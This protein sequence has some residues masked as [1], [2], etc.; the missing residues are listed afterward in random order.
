[1]AGTRDSY[2]LEKRFIR[3][4]GEVVHV[5][6]SVVPV[7]HET[8]AVDY[9]LILAQDITKRKRAEEQ[10]QL[11]KF[12]VDRSSQPIYWIRTDGRI[13]YANQAACAALG[14]SFEELVSMSVPQIDPDF[15][16]AAWPK[17]WEEMKQSGSMTFEARHKRKD[18]HMFPVELTTHY[19]EHLGQEYVWAFVRDITERRRMEEDNRRLTAA[20]D[21]TTE[22]ILI[23]DQQGII[24]YVNPAFEQLTGYSAEEALGQNPRMLA[25]GLHDAEFYRPLWERICSGKVWS[26]RFINAKKDGTLYEQETTISPVRN[27][28]GKI[29]NFVS[30]RRDVTRERELEIQLRQSHKMEAVGQLASGVAHDLNNL[31]TVISTASQ[32]L[33]DKVS[34]NE[35]A[36]TWLDSMNQAVAQAT[37]MTRSLLTFGRKLPVRKRHIQLQDEIKS[38]ARMLSHSLPAGIELIVE[39]ECDQPIWVYAD[40]TS[41]QQIILNLAV[42]ARDAM[43]DGG[44]LR[45]QVAPPEVFPE[46]ALPSTPPESQQV[47][48][49]MSDTGSGMSAEVR[50]RI[51]DPFFTTKPPGQGTGLGLA[52]VHGIVQDHGGSIRVQSQVGGPTS[53]SIFLPCV[54]PAE[55]PGALAVEATAELTGEGIVLLAEDHAQVREIIAAGLNSVGFTV[56]Q[57]NDGQEFLTAANHLSENLRLL[58][59]DVDLPKKDGL[60]C[61][62]SLRAAGLEVP[63]I[64][65]TGSNIAH[66]GDLD[67]GQT[68]LLSKPFAVGDLQRLACRLVSGSDDETTALTVGSQEND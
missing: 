51:F 18:G 57:V 67:D 68:V 9:F 17:H 2:V 39:I 54:A 49:T 61:L 46:Q 41:L 29:V 36:L 52:V 48:I 50:S 34:D 10:S 7:R 15:P 42:N 65:V 14:Y 20:I 26:G 60:D 13:A 6:L 62:R 64:V 30:V 21:Q 8:G 33:R 1:M 43:P 35:Q 66:L 37:E 28:S 55:S 3:Q 45:I 24:Q 59:L 38:A 56:K 19:M 58:V 12:A 11:T 47:R 53:F 27:A 22:A 16:Q 40:P 32:L 63:A 25:S 44:T 31:L 23:T 5:I 4:D